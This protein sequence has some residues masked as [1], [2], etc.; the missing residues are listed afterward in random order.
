MAEKINNDLASSYA[1]HMR[2]TFVYFCRIG[3]GQFTLQFFLENFYPLFEKMSDDK[4]P[5]VRMEFAKSLSEVK[6][7]IE[8]G[9]L[10]G[11]EIK[12]ELIEKIEKLKADEDADVA[13]ATD[14]M[15]FELLQKRK[16]QADKYL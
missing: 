7:F 6:P 4:V 14:D 12:Y 3:A 13:E 1:F 16:I 15:D 8:D 2:K 10:E 11:K 9:V 5:Q